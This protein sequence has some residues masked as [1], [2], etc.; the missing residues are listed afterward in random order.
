[1]LFFGWYREGTKKRAKS[2]LRYLSEFLSH[3]EA[4]K[5]RIYS[6]L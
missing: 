5:P 1:M 4:E 6:E 3:S 2:F